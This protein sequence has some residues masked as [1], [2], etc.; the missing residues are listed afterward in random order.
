MKFTNDEAVALALGLAA[1]RQLGVAGLDDAVT[2]ALAK[3][4]RVLP[5]ELR[6]R[7]RALTESTLLSL[8]R[9]SAPVAHATL[10]LLSAAAQARQSMQ[11]HYQSR[12]SVKTQR[13]FDAY[14]VVFRDACWYVIGHCHLRKAVR[15]FR[16]D[17]IVNV[18]TVTQ[19]FVRPA[20]F[21]PQQHLHD[22][23]AKITRAHTLRVVCQGTLEQLLHELPREAF[24]F[25]PTANGIV[26]HGTVDDL[27]W[28]ARILARLSDPFR[29]EQP[30]ALRTALRAH[31]KALTANVA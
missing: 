18:T 30:A 6:L 7:L 11:L 22:A 4:E 2:G 20:G 8:Q 19:T 14:G 13:L 27:D 17:R 16:V 21:D 31:V 25:E 1:V 12:E 3:L 24:F 9:T 26:V 5:L 10:L 29:I 23:I 15:S 28:T